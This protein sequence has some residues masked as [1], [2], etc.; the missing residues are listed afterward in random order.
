M[1]FADI[2]LIS[3][4]TAAVAFLALLVLAS[5]SWQ[6]GAV[7]PWLIVAC[8][9]TVIWSVAAAYDF[10]VDHNIA[11]LVSALEIVRTA[12]WIAFLT[13]VLLHSRLSGGLSSQWRTILGSIFTICL[14]LVIIELTGA[15]D[16]H[17]SLPAGSPDLAILARLVLAV[18]RDYV[19]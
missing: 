8:A 5:I 1:T 18:R 12:A 9:A 19:C 6:R 17:K 7:G 2:G 4:V 13:A 15:I 11:W 10:V 16:L 3:H 14:A